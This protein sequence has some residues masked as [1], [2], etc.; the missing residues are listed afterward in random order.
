M[1]PRQRLARTRAR[2]RHERGDIGDPASGLVNLFDLWMVFAVAA[3]L[4]SVGA[5]REAL[6]RVEADQHAL[7]E[8]LRSTDRA[9][10]GRGERLGVAYRLSSGE[11]VYVPEAEESDP[12]DELPR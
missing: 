10:E 1:N 5:A 2:R 6:Q 3:L 7:P 9:L 12:T 11:V 4:T 8:A